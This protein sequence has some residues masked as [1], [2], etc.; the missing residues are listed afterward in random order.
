MSEDLTN[1]VD[2]QVDLDIYECLRPENPQSFFLFAGAG[3]GKTRSLV[4]VLTRF[5]EEYGKNLRLVKRKV[6]IITYTNAASEEITHRLGYDSI[7]EVS[8]IHSFAWQL[9]QNF[10]PDIKHWLSN[11]LQKEIETLNDEQSRSRDLNNKTSQARAKKILSKGA[12]LAK[13]PEVV[14]FKYNPNGD[15]T[16]KDSLNHSEVISIAAEFLGTKSLMQ[17]ILVSQFPILLI[18]ESQDTNKQLIDALFVLQQA[19]KDSFSLGLFGDTMQRIYL[20]GKEKLDQSLPPDWVQPA[21]KMNHRSNKRIITLINSIRQQVDTQEQQPRPEKQDGFVRLFLCNRGLNKDQVEK[22]IGKKMAEITSDELWDREKPGNNVMTLILEHHMA[23][24]RL[25]FLDLFEPLYSEDRY[26]TGLLDGSLS[27]LNFF[28]KIIYPLY[29]ARLNDDKFAIANIVK[30]NSPLLKKEELKQSAEQYESLKRANVALDFLFS[31]WENDPNPPLRN[32]LE[33]I[34]E[35]GLFE[36]PPMLAAHVSSPEGRDFVVP[37]SIEE[38]EEQEEEE[39]TSDTTIHVWMT[40]LGAPF[41]QLVAYND[42]ITGESHFGTHQGVKG[43]EFPRVAVILDDEESR[44]FQFSYDKLFGAKALSRTDEENI[45]AGRESGFD[46]TR[47]LFY[48]ACSRARESL[49]IIAYSDNL[50]AI[51]A[52]ALRYGWFSEGEI[53]MAQTLLET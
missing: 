6:A 49:A 5:K 48:V 3:S 24:R 16:T 7:F 2:A 52:N 4:E 8:T 41:S 53:V 20:D 50:E 19:K 18:D 9:I 42:Y 46:K 13:L 44:G 14:K 22:A 28:T 25:G 27:G 38:N 31:V 39:E 23:A 40:A 36:I 1:N 11:N 43:L 51:K 17:E 32:I 45:A 12:R 30:S 35:S 15:N 29:K 10:T 21:K 37:R 47:R 34:S 26:S 33:N